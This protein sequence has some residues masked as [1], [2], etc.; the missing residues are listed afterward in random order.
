MAERKWNGRCRGLQHHWLSNKTK[1]KTN[2]KKCW[3]P[4]RPEIRVWRLAAK[5]QTIWTES[6]FLLGAVYLWRRLL[7]LCSSL[8]FSFFY[9]GRIDGTDTHDATIYQRPLQPA[10]VWLADVWRRLRRIQIS[11]Q[12]AANKML[13]TSSLTAHCSHTSWWFTW[14]DLK[15]IGSFEYLIFKKIS[16]I[17]P[18]DRHV[19]SWKMADVSAPV[20]AAA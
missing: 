8:A 4:F 14:A 11:N 16:R 17:R 9:G 10:P 5:R 20:I 12:T 3:M 1:Q 2:K 6:F 19:Q 18:P 13:M 7:F 15:A